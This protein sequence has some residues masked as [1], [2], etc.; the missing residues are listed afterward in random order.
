MRPR[1]LCVYIVIS[2]NK[3]FLE[4]F[5]NYCSVLKHIYI[6]KSEIKDLRARMPFSMITKLK[7]RIHP[8]IKNYCV[9]IWYHQRILT[10]FVNFNESKMAQV[11]LML[12]SCILTQFVNFN[13]SKM[14]QV[15]LML[16]SYILTK[17]VNFN[18]RKRGQILYKDL[19]WVI[20]ISRGLTDLGRK[21]NLSGLKYFLLIL[22]G[23][24]W[25]PRTELWLIVCFLQ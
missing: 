22:T 3:L 14:S 21:A 17:F 20:C 15:F 8:S 2:G 19:L 13:E 18:E 9:T 7:S 4:K 5:C 24:C 1:F 6:W 23:T 16:M 12:M 10:K 11:F 25:F